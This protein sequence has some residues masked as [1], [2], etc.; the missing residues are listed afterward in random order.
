MTVTK[1]TIL[2]KIATA[3]HEKSRQLPMLMMAVK[4]MHQENVLST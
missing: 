1:R 3:S 4:V 2:K